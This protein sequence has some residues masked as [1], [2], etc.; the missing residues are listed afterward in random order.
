M[1]RISL[2]LKVLLVLS[3]LLSIVFVSCTE[4]SN[5]I[6]EADAS[7]CNSCGKCVEVCPVKAITLV[8]GKAVID[9]AKCNKCGKCAVICPTDAIK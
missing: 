9:V 4:K 6:F 8:N 7:A 5:S 1:K 3:C 2:I